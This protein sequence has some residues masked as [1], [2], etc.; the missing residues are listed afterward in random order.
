M[1]PHEFD[2]YVNCPRFCALAEVA[3]QKSTSPKND[4]NGLSVSQDAILV[5]RRS[6]RW[7]PNRMARLDQSNT[8]RYKSRDGD[9]IPWR[10]DNPTAA[11]G[12]ER[13][14][15]CA[16][17]HPVTGG[18][19]TPHTATTG[20]GDRSGCVEQGRLGQGHRVVLL[21]KFL[22]GF[23]R[24]AVPDCCPED[25]AVSDTAWPR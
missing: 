20:D 18:S 24:Q 3:W 13:G 2:L 15:V 17:Q 12:Q 14:L 25:G 8:S 7:R 19:C 22:G 9:P 6:S 1:S 5:Y 16:I 10:D 21:R 11:G 23:F 4:T